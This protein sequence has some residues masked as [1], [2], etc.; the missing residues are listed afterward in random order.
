MNR[1][2]LESKSAF[3]KISS[4][5]ESLGDQV[6]KFSNLL[7]VFVGAF[8]AVSLVVILITSFSYECRLTKTIEKINLFLERNPR[9]NDDN[10]IAF[11]NLMKG[12]NVPKVLRRQWQQF[13]LYREQPASHYMS[14]KHCVENP[15]RNSS[16]YQ[17]MSV[18]KV[19]TYVLAGLSFVISVF[20]ATSSGFANLV[21]REVVIIPLAILVCYWLISMALDLIH[22]GITNDL[23]Q[24]YQYFEIN[25]DKAVLTLPDFVDYEVLFSQDEIKKGIPVLFAYLQKRAVQEQQE[26]EKARLTSVNHEKFDFDKAGLDGSLVLDRAMR[27]T[28]NYASQRKKFNQ[29]IE[30]VNNEIAS[31]ENNYKEQVKEYQR[32][33]QTGK[34]TVDNLKAQL[35]QAS[36]TI[37]MNYIKKQIRDEINRQQY[38][39]KDFDIANDK[40]NQEIKS[41]KQEIASYEEEIAK[42]KA[43]LEEAMHSE[44]STY[45]VKVYNNLEKVVEEKVQDE[46]NGFK[47]RIR[48]LEGELEDKSE[49]LES[50]Y[51]RYQ[52]IVSQTGGG[53]NL[54]TDDLESGKK[55]KKK[56]GKLEAPIADW[57][58]SKQ[59]TQGS[60]MSEQNYVPVDQI[61]TTTYEDNYQVHNNTA[62]SDYVP[63]QDNYQPEAQEDQ[64]NYPSQDVQSFDD[65]SGFADEV[66]NSSTTTEASNF[67]YVPLSD[68]DAESNQSNSNDTFEYVPLDEENTKPVDSFKSSTKSSQD[69]FDDSDFDFDFDEKPSTKATSFKDEDDDDFL[70]DIDLDDSNESIDEN[71]LNNQEESDMDDFDLDLLDTEVEDDEGEDDFDFDLEEDLPDPTTVK[72]KAGRPRKIVDEDDIKPKRGPGRPKKKVTNEYITKPKKS[73][74]RPR[75]EDSS[76]KVAKRSVGRPKKTEGSSSKRSVGRPKK[77]GRPRKVGR[78]KKR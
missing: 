56:K 48:G 4:F 18:Y 49:E 24:N 34:E 73:V 17:E 59:Y 19:I 27:E 31:F 54:T 9:I 42:A 70:P 66:T 51:T 6:G 28:E 22:N 62:Q 39:E 35:E 53:V 63:Q 10:L 3:D 5:F 69:V 20:M 40:Y 41:L 58:N 47:N 46:L 77:V 67:E 44:F 76:E 74:G 1:F 55:K 2:L 50:I 33:V 71:K 75:K 37:E 36:S 45:S 14:F 12:R 13:M 52:E 61:T 30:R 23:F 26:L 72:R 43:S 16:Y 21:L 32:Q 65:F 11:N 8:L 60:S 57:N 25:I 7:F 78:P 68:L 15:M 38:A 29:E 64:F